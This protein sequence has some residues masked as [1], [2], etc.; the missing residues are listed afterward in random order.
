MVKMNFGGTA[1]GGVIAARVRPLAD[2]GGKEFIR[3]RFI[4]ATAANDASSIVFFRWNHQLADDML[5]TKGG[6]RLVAEGGNVAWTHSGCWS[7]RG[8]GTT[9]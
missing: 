7:G 1:N 3:A 8:K 9:L 2:L 4:G 6:L 5:A